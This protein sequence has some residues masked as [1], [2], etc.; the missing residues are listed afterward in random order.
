PVRVALGALLG[1]ALSIGADRLNRREAAREQLPTAPSYVPPA[2]AAAG[3]A[4]LFASIYAAYALYGLLSP[5]PAFVLLAMIAGATAAQSLRHGPL[6]AALGLVGAYVVPALVSSDA[7]HAL[8]LFTYLAVATAGAL[9]LLRHRAWWWLACLTITGALLW[10]PL[11]L[12]AA[13]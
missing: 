9:A 5:A 4:T 3:A 2:L 1:I 7:P 10:V 6:V 12:N 11:W 8:P 13:P